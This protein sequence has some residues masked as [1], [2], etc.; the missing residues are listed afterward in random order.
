MLLKY[1]IQKESQKPYQRYILK[2]KT[3]IYLDLR[4]IIYEKSK[5]QRLKF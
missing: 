2:E 5:N 1:V 3:Y 4:S